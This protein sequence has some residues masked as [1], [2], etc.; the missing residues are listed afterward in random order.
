[1]TSR[2]PADDLRRKRF[3]E[4]T[5]MATNRP[6]P[7]A[8]NLAPTDL[9][10]AEDSIPVSADRVRVP[11]VL[12]RAGLLF[13]AD[14]ASRGLR[15]LAD[16]LLVR[17]FGRSAFGQL[18]V[19]QSLTVQGVW[20]STCGLNTA[21]VR[22]VAAAPE[23]AQRIAATVVVL[24]CCL[25]TVTWVAIAG[26]SFIVPQYHDSFQL[27]A[28]Y[29]LSLFTG[30]L[31]IGWVGQG[32]GD[33]RPMGL[34]LLVVH[35]VYVA[36]VQLVIS[37]SLPLVCVPIVLI[38]A[39]TLTVAALW[40][41]IV[42]DIGPVLRPLPLGEALCFLREAL[43]IGGAN[44]LRGIMPGSD[45]LLLRLFVGED[46]VGQYA[47]A[48]KLY[49][50]GS[51]LLMAYFAVVFP[52]LAS[53]AAKSRHE[54]Q[55]A[56]STG[57]R[58]SLLAALPLTMAGLA[59]APFLLSVL[60]GSDFRDAAG[61]LRVLFLVLPLQLLAGQWRA[62]LVALGR[63]RYDLGLVTVGA[64]VHVGTKL[65][66]IPALGIVGAAWGTFAGEVTLMVLSW[67]AIRTALRDAE[68]V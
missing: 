45:I 30:A 25:S 36:G 23:T 65:G 60:F 61:I 64:V 34:A 47:A 5:A 53:R 21:G 56:M 11:G 28:M 46:D 58:R 15:F 9:N 50:L 10:S 14:V 24:R 57:I 2:V 4:T 33:V 40:W 7:D 8:G 37:R 35:I 63:Q 6:A 62:A 48:L 12:G 3:S 55:A 39:E 59:L 18:N 32:R 51:A 29:C 16:I 13:A 49:S 27:V 41:W 44:L 67:Y 17:H 66:L 1:M 26:L 43:P 42:R 68:R 38:V 22:T 52:H 31:N 19:A 20:I 54:L